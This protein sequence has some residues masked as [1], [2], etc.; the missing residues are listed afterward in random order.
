MNNKTSPKCAYGLEEVAQFIE[1]IIA[2]LDRRPERYSQLTPADR[3]MWAGFPAQVRAHRYPFVFLDPDRPILAYL[4]SG[5]I[6]AE[7][8]RSYDAQE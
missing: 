4:K 1:W 6:G 2:D 3:V 7:F 8:T 5:L